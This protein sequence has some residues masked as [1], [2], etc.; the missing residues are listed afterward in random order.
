MF[1][2]NLTETW[3]CLGKEPSIEKMF[4][5]RLVVGIVKFSHYVIIVGRPKPAKGAISK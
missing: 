1:F 3:T 5:I 2:V 4:P